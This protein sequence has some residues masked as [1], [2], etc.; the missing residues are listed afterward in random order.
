[1]DAATST[2]SSIAGKEVRQR[3]P[4]QLEKPQQANTIDEARRAVVDLNAAEDHKDESEKRTFGRTA[5]GT[6]GSFH[7]LE[8][9]RS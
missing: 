4:Q 7:A 2:G 8:Q 9:L 1:M 6:G 5:D 3:L